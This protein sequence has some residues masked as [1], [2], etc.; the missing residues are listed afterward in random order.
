MFQQA[1]AQTS[2]KSGEAAT[3]PA[4]TQT[5]SPSPTTSPS[6]D[7]PVPAPFKLTPYTPVVGTQPAPGD[8]PGSPRFNNTPVTDV[9]RALAKAA[10]MNIQ[11]D[12]RL[13]LPTITPDGRTNT[14]VRNISIAWDNITAADALQQVV[15]GE[16]WQMI[17]NP[18]TKVGRIGPKDLPGQEPMFSAIFQLRY[19]NPTNT[20]TLLRA[21]LPIRSIVVADVRT[22]KIIVVATQTDLDRLKEYLVLLDSPASQIL[23]EARFL[24]TTANPTSVKGIDWTGTLNAQNLSFG[25]G[26]TAVNSVSTTTPSAGGTSTTPGGRTITG[27]P[28]DTTTTSSSATTTLPGL[29][30]LSGMSLNT[31]K[32]FSPATA[33]LNADGL[34]AVLSFLNTDAQTESLATP[35]AV[36]SDGIP[37]TL[38][39]VRNIPVFEQTQGANVAGSVQPNTVKPNYDLKSGTTILNE[40]GIK[41]IVTPRVVGETNVQLALEPEISN[42]ELVP[43]STTLGGQVSTAPIF[44]RRKLTTTSIIPSG[45]TLVLGGLVNDSSI[46]SSTKVPIL[47]DIPFIGLAFRHESK[48]LTKDNLMIFVTPTIVQSEDF[49]RNHEAKTF[50]GTRPVVKMDLNPN[51]LNTGEPYDWTKPR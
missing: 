16:N 15:E 24:E 19:A 36:T 32:G 27:S 23:I 1:R 7:V 26:L 39:V 4:P 41:L 9:I 12:P 17:V 25:N 21:M 51:A 11:F 29:S 47:G 33:F 49:Q 31:A 46:K 34:N 14:G 22:S 43:A 28:G 2:V 44:A 5:N 13:L 35:R 30:T 8:E 48:A 6:V 3:A 18:R 40:V 38:S 10:G 50:F 20:V 45:Y 37:T 42:Q